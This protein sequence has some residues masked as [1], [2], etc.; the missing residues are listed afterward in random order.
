MYIIY[1]QI[2]FKNKFCNIKMYNLI[3]PNENLHKL[4]EDSEQYGKF[5]YQNNKNYQLISNVME[6]PE[7]RTFIDTYFNDYTDIDTI[8]LF[9]K[10]YQSLDNISVNKIQ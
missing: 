8:L 3:K 2:K 10:L 9:I 5:L 7:F 1:K 6:H 4:L